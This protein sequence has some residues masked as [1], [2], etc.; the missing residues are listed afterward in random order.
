MLLVVWFHKISKHFLTKSWLLSM[1]EGLSLSTQIIN[2]DATVKIKNLA[3]CLITL[4]HFTFY[5]LKLNN[6]VFLQNSIEGSRRLEKGK[7]KWRV[8]NSVSSH[9]HHKNWERKHWLGYGRHFTN[10]LAMLQK[11]FF[12]MGSVVRCLF[13]FCFCT[14]PWEILYL[15]AFLLAES[16]GDKSIGLKV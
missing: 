12:I 8:D 2:P 1:C 13:L 6:F 14:Y 7:Q 11:L 16:T 5:H 9:R 15:H 10:K 3:C 4:S